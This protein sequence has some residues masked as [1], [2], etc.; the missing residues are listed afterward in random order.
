[1]LEGPPDEVAAVLA[2]LRQGPA[3]ARVETVEVTE[4]PVEGLRGFEIG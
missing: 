3:Y 2:W 1:M 4:E